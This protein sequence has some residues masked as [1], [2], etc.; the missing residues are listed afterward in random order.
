MYAFK[1]YNLIFSNLESLYKNRT[2]VPNRFLMPICNHSTSHPQPQPTL[3]IPSSPALLNL[4]L[5]NLICFLSQ[6][7]HPSGY[8]T[9]TDHD[10][11]GLC[12]C[13]S[14]L[15]C[16]GRIMPHMIYALVCL[17]C[18]GRVTPCVLCGLISLLGT[19][20]LH[21]TAA[22]TTPHYM[23]TTQMA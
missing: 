1:V 14:Q 6:W 2:T 16:L 5:D 13:F 23:G 20:W 17:V 9:C 12:F 19:S 15:A 10:T 8:L 4:H 3:Y 21:Q 22:H 7:I 18:L 11:C